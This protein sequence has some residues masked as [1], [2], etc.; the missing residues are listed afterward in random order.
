MTALPSAWIDPAVADRPRPEPREPLEG[1]ATYDDVVVGGGLVGLLTALLLA[2][3][4]RRVAVL[5]ARRVGEGTTGRSTGK[6]SLLQGTRLSRALRSHPPSVLRTFVEAEREGQAWLRRFCADHDVPIQERPAYTYAT[7]RWG[8]VR[9][10][11]ELETARTVGLDVE[12][13][14]TT[15][16][17][18]DVRGAVRLDGQ[19]QIDP[20]AVLDAVRTELEAEGGEVYEQSRVQV[21]ERAGDDTVRLVTDAATVT[22]QHAVIATNQPATLRGGYFARLKTQR[23]Y[24][25]VLGC[26]RPPQG[27]YLSS[28]R[29][30]YSIR[31]VPA[32]GAGDDLLLVGGNGHPTGR[33][34]SER[35]HLDALV[36]WAQDAWRGSTVFDA[37]SAQDQSPVGSLPYVGPLVPGDASMLV[38]TGFSKWGLATSPAAALVLSKTILGD[39]PAWAEAFA[40]WRPREVAA[41]PQALLYNAEVGFQMAAGHLVRPQVRPHLTGSGR[42]DEGEGVVR[43]TGVLPSG[44]STVGG[45]TREVSAVCPHLGGVLRWNDAECSWDCP[46]HGSRFAPDG[47]VL[48]GPA[49][50]PLKQR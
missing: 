39:P 3:A 50:R 26:P 19:F 18:F 28:D 1:M 4:G 6:V 13:V 8:E 35:Q 29:L 41:V 49:T 21:V 47:A 24:A 44:V 12:W 23:S 2:R 31:S 11:A 32:E 15:E 36:A 17:P 5:E 34:T 38:A 14:D 7:T 30:T 43:R 10:Q 45:V 22:A 37:W 27:L 40:A 25:A 33:T 48:E 20:L 46:L 16:L 9:A 42:P